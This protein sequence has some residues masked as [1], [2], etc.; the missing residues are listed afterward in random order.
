WP[1]SGTRSRSARRGQGRSPRSSTGSQC[2]NRVMNADVVTGAAGLVAP[3]G[4]GGGGPRARA[5]AAG[6]GGAAAPPRGSP[7][8][9]PGGEPG[10]GARGGGA[11]LATGSI[12]G[13]AKLGALERAVGM[14]DPT[15]REGADTPGRVRGLCAKARQPAPAA[16]AVP[17]VAAVCVYPDLVALAR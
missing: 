17:P 7:P 9:P 4:A 6:G 11:S 3:R 2:D 16:P 8:A 15:T 1:P 12:R 10:G 13:E 14:V 5:P